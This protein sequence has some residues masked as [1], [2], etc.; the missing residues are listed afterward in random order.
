MHFVRTTAGCGVSLPKVLTNPLPECPLAPAL[1][2]RMRQ[3]RD[4]LTRRWL[5]R[6]AA[7]VSLD[8]NKIFPTDDLLDHVPILIDGIAT[9]IE[10]PAE[11]IVTDASVIAKAMELGQMRHEQGFDAYQVFKEYE[12][13]GSVI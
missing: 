13:L 7:R 4:D 8:A 6:I 3:S 10:N 5:A 12:I 2:A 9:Y 11:H 1:A